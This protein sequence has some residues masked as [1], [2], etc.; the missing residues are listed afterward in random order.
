MPLLHENDYQIL[1]DSG[2]EYVEEESV[3]FLVIKNYPLPDGKYVSDGKILKTVEILVVIPGNY[4][5]IGCDMFWVFPLLKRAD[6]K[7]IPNVSE[8]GG[9]DPRHFKGKEYCRWSRH[10]KPNTWKPK[11]DNIQKILDRIEWALRNP[12]ANK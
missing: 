8:V 7:N 6:G 12:D 9:S 10:Y 1:E 4:N 3:R 5:T 11:V 2:L